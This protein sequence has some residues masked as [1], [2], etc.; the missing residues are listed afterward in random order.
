[1]LLFRVGQVVRTSLLVAGLAT[2]AAAQE[3]VIQT[4]VSGI[5]FDS[6]SMKPLVGAL[7]RMVR[8]N[9]PSI[10]RSA[11]SDTSGSFHYDSVASG[12]WLASFLHPTLD[13]LGLEPGIVRVEIAD[14]SALTMPM[15]TPSG[16]TLF[17][18]LCGAAFPSEYGVV[19]GEVR[20]AD[21]DSPIV[22]ATVEVDWPEWVL[23][24]RALLTETRRLIVRTDSS[25]RYKI[26]GVPA[27]ST[28]RA[29]TWTGADSSGFVEV[30]VPASGYTFQDFSVGTLEYAP[31][32]A[33]AA[34]VA[35]PVR[36][37]QSMVHG[38]VT[39]ST[40]V[41]LQNASV[42]VLGS[43]TPVRTSERGEF[44]ILDAI[45]GTQSI[46]VRAIGYQPLRRAVRLSRTSM[47]EVTFSMAA[48]NVEL[49]T[50]R[51]VAGREIPW[52]VRGIERRWRTGLG[53]FLDGKTV[54][55]RSTMYTTDALRGM[56]G[57]AIRSPK[58]GFGQDI[59]M[60]GFMGGECRA[61]LFVDGM[62]VDAASRGGITIDEFVQPDMVA[63]VEVYARANLVPAEYMTMRTGCGVV[64]VW[65]KNGTGNVPVLPPKSERR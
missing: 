51:V 60:R 44:V 57:V 13:S 56:A 49:D 28:L 2:S 10:G 58:Q 38:R 24:T 16:R 29:V 15:F 42:R 39:T 50:V 65:T 37:G 20:R 63:A 1:M 17:A 40:G 14:G 6:V 48:T 21:D 25:G 61:T 45:L 31:G 9:D 12:A 30:S 11:V 19:V 43:G 7:V 59:I 27:T 3:P 22:G 47:V 46:E 36:R 35:G 26:C 52:D 8:A 64:A 54:T 5:V 62:P 23:Q 41:G 33:V 55:E 53:R 34:A 32:S 4:R 18:T